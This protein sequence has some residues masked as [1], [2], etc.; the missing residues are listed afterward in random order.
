MSSIFSRR[1]FLRRSALV[2]IPVAVAG[3]TV[4]YES[5]Q[6]DIYVKNC[7]SEPKEIELAVTCRKNDRTVY[8]EANEI[9]ADYC[10][11][12][13][14]SYGGEEVW[15]RS[16]EYTIRAEVAGMTPVE[17]TVL[18]SASEEKSDDDSRTIYIDDGEITIRTINSIDDV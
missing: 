14:N 15:E 13:G 12:M 1:G 8:D 18:L 10:S 16:G 11:D 6:A 9:P 3:C 17:R 2:S 4:E 7:Y 5:G